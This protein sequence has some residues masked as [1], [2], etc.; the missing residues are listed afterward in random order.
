MPLA[1]INIRTGSRQYDPIWGGLSNNLPDLGCIANI[2]I[3]RSHCDHFIATPP[4][5]QRLAQQSRTAKNEY[6]HCLDCRLVEALR[7]PQ[8]NSSLILGRE[9]RFPFQIPFNLQLR[10]IPRESAFVFRRIVVSRFV[11]NLCRCRKDQESMRKSLRY[12]QHA[13]VFARETYG[14][15][16]SEPFGTAS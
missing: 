11:E 16:L 15:A 10:I 7:V 13:L 3:P 5:H 6:S 8:Q 1:A 14:C 9:N 12:P 2:D 4:A